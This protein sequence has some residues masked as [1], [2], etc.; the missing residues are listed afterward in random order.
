MSRPD[1]ED[2]IAEESPK[3]WGTDNDEK[4]RL[5]Y[6]AFEA[7]GIQDFLARDVVKTLRNAG[8]AFEFYGQVPT[9]AEDKADRD[10]AR[11]VYSDEIKMAEEPVEHRLR[12]AFLNGMR[13][14]MERAMYIGRWDHR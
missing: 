3:A 4:M 14:G 8:I 5:V 12:R 10:V 11:A 7:A 13:E 6:G 2:S 1:H 9:D